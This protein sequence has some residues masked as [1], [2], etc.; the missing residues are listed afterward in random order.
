MSKL[1]KFIKR[2]ILFILLL[3]ICLALLLTSCVRTTCDLQA[4]AGGSQ[5]CEET[6][7]E[8]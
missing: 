1:R 2:P 3:H 7:A 6:L 5:Y 8:E 4:V